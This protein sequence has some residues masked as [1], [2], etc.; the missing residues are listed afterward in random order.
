MFES[1]ANYRVHSYNARAC[2]TICFAAPAYRMN[3]T[4]RLSGSVR[5][6]GRDPTI[7]MRVTRLVY[8]VSTPPTP[9]AVTRMIDTKLT[10]ATVRI[11]H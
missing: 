10:V 2:K 5:S 7:C 11:N 4:F 1:V 3:V 6:A 9:T 8:W